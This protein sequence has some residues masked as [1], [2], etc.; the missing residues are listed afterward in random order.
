[1]I[2]NEKAILITGADGYVGSRVAA[3]LLKSGHD[4]LVLWL[5]SESLKEFEEK[6]ARMR[7]RLGDRSELRFATG[8][9]REQS[10]FES[11]NPDDIDAII[12]SAAVT[13]FN[14]ERDLA[15]SVN[16]RGTAAAL[17]FASKCKHLRRFMLVSSI[18]ASGLEA[19]NISETT[20]A[21]KYG[22]ANFYEESKWQCE[23]KVQQ[24]YLPWQIARVATIVSDSSEGAVSQFN[25]VHNTLKL[26]YYG[27]LPL[28]PGVHDAKLYFTTGSFVVRALADILQYGSSNGI[29]HVSA[30]YSNAVCLNELIETAYKTFSTDANFQR[31]RVLPPLYADIDSFMAL[32]DSMVNFGQG[33]MSQASASVSPFAKQ[34]FI[35]KKVHTEALSRIMPNYEQPDINRLIPE[36]CDWLVQNKW[37]KAHVTA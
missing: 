5:R 34:L 30:D 2:A 25:A 15:Q 7:L 1:M 23:Q 8:D 11:L 18:Y 33:I 22:F 3:D 36:L 13:R 27:M 32:C 10:P 19:G 4:N 28:V 26:F 17:E 24:S 6:V 12:H 21:G 37:G 9:L 20:F 31:R 35:H 29:Y 16:V 14:V